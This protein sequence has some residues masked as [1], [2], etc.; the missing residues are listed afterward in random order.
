MAEKLIWVRPIFDP[1]SWHWINP[2]L[3]RRFLA[4]QEAKRK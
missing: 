2:E 4:W 3:A 1:L